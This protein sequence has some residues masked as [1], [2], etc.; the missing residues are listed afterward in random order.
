[1]ERTGVQPNVVIYNNLLKLYFK[2]KNPFK[3]AELWERMT[4][5]NSGIRPTE[6][7]Y[8]IVFNGIAGMVDSASSVVRQS[9]LF[10]RLKEMGLHIWETLRADT[11]VVPGPVLYNCL[12]KM[13]CSLHMIP[14]AKSVFNELLGEASPFHN[15]TLPPQPPHQHTKQETKQQPPTPQPRRTKLV[16][17][18][19]IYNT[20]MHGLLNADGP[21]AA[22]AVYD[23]LLRQQLVPDAYTLTIY[24]QALCRQ[25]R[26]DDAIQ[27][28]QRANP[29]STQS[30]LSPQQSQPMRQTQQ[31]PIRQPQ[32]QTPQQSQ[33]M[34]QTQ[35]QRPMQY[36]LNDR[37]FPNTV[38]YSVR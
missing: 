30:N 24:L 35:P 11:R 36:R 12:L 15:I 10:A 29:S 37:T 9:D 5:S 6:V 21:D 23:T 1:M 16:P 2:K 20:M 17:N 34:R 4:V 26:I 18:L 7:S 14:Q 33:P 31:R 28:V 3:A 32:P 25:G 22:L 27:L 19:Y 8:G 38:S 13:L